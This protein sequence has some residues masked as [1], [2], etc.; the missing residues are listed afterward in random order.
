MGECQSACNSEESIRAAL[1]QSIRIEYNGE[2]FIMPEHFS[3][4]KQ[5][6]FAKVEQAARSFCQRCPS[7]TQKTIFPSSTR[8]YSRAS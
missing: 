8:P 3:F 2:R 7:L 4:D 1:E 6:T 5:A